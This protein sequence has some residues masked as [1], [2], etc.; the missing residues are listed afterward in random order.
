MTKSELVREIMQGIEAMSDGRGDWYVDDDRASVRVEGDT[1]CVYGPED[2]DGN[3]PVRRFRLVE[4]T[5]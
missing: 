1:L 4:V 3:M 5:E 2:E